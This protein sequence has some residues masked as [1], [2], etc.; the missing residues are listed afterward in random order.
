MAMT[1]QGPRKHLPLKE[2]LLLAARI[3][4]GKT[5]K[6]P[7]KLLI[8][9]RSIEQLNMSMESSHVENKAFRFFFSPEYTILLED[10]ERCYKMQDGSETFAQC[11]TEEK[12]KVKV[13]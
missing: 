12:V 9:T 3:G 4:M 13:K 8:D 5:T 11:Q 6:I 10:N 2:I 7:L 1:T